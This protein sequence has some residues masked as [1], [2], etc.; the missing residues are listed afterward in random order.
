MRKLLKHDRK[1]FTLIEIIVV[2]TIL[3][4]LIAFL[5]PNLMSYLGAANSTSDDATARLVYTSVIAYAAQEKISLTTEDALS[6][7]T[8]ANLDEIAK[9]AGL[10]AGQVMTTGAEEAGK[11]LVKHSA[12]EGITVKFGSGEYP[13]PTTTT[14]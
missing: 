2:L 1:G 10:K 4:V 9:M 5:V 6:G 14:P 8:E 3:A 13:A 7:L 11:A 12:T